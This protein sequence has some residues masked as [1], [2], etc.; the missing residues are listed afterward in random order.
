MGLWGDFGGNIIIYKDAGW[1][2]AD[3]KPAIVTLQHDS[4][5]VEH[6]TTPNSNRAVK[7][8]GYYLEKRLM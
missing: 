2:Y 5:G 1:V 8:D 7:G 6:K 3:F 4:L